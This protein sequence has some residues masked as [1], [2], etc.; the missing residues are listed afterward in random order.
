MNRLPC[1]HCPLAGR[2]LYN[3][4]SQA[5]KLLR[6]LE[7]MLDKTEESAQVLLTSFMR[8][9][10]FLK[11][12]K[13]ISANDELTED[14]KWAAKLRLDQPLIIAAG[15]R[16]HAWPEDDPALL[17]ALIA[18]FVM[19]NERPSEPL[20]T[21]RT[22]PPE[23]AS[24]WLRL[25]KAVDPLVRRQREKGFEVPTLNMRAALAI[26]TWATRD[27]WNEAVRIYGKDE[28]DL[29]MLTFRTAD[30]LRQLAS[31]YETHP[32]LAVSARRAR[33]LILRE[34]VTVPL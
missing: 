1:N 26:Y 7:K 29:A 22:L 27:D 20:A 5:F 31:L 6:R 23:F 13:F 14:G 17:A 32:A 9:L 3:K 16:A 12:E 30:N 11:E 21:L 8:H 15:I 4:N 2:C 10:N 18:P 19:D 28:G 34:P 24:A 33:D 25:E